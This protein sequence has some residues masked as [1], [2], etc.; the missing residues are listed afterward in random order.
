MSSFPQFLP[1]RH[2]PSSTPIATHV[3]F[4]SVM[5]TVQRCLDSERMSWRLATVQCVDLPSQNLPQKRKISRYCG[6]SKV[7]STQAN[8]WL[9]R[10]VRIICT[11]HGSIGILLP[12]TP[13][14]TGTMSWKHVN[15]RCPITTKWFY[16]PTR[17]PVPKQLG[18]Q[19]FSSDEDDKQRD[20]TFPKKNADEHRASSKRKLCSRIAT[21]NLVALIVW[22]QPTAFRRSH[23]IVCACST[24][25]CGRRLRLCVSRYAFLIAS[26]RSSSTIDRTPSRSS[27][28]IVTLFP[29]LFVK[30]STTIRLCGTHLHHALRVCMLLLITHNFGA[31][32]LHWVAVDS[33]AKWSKALLASLTHTMDGSSCRWVSAFMKSLWV[34]RAMILIVVGATRVPSLDRRLSPTHRWS[35]R[36]RPVPHS[37]WRPLQP[38]TQIHFVSLC[39]TT[40]T[41]VICLW[42]TVMT[43]QV[44]SGIRDGHGAKVDQRYRMDQES[45]IVGLLQPVYN[46]VGVRQVLNHGSDTDPCRVEAVPASSGR[47]CRATQDREPATARNALTSPR[48]LLRSCPN[49]VLAALRLIVAVLGR[50]FPCQPWNFDQA[51]VWSGVLRKRT[52]RPATIGATCQT[53]LSVVISSCF[54]GLL[55]P[56]QPMHL[57]VQSD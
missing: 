33:R 17:K 31:D 53:W 10:F 12:P 30:A 27:R 35:T 56:Y 8:Q 23:S 32:R 43:V 39:A 38:Q 37:P 46:A 1:S 22:E 16:F 52:A 25:W 24:C 55:C 51:T 44:K 50:I 3:A 28:N 5:P 29:C 19:W 21:R 18:Q 26:S 49:I 34:L 11:K 6:Q 41:W 13:K 48:L 47:H 4:H 36:I 9:S 54:H 20:T 40:R 15:Q 2:A 57:A 45:H 42:R 7:P 14:Q